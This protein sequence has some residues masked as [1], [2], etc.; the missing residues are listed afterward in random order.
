MATPRRLTPKKPGS[1]HGGGNYILIAMPNPNRA[2]AFRAAVASLEIETVLVRDGEK[3]NQ[4]LGRRG[5]PILTIVDLSLPKIDGFELLRELRKQA[6]SSEAAVIVVSGHSA[7]RMAAERL[8]ESLGISK[9]LPFDIDRTALREA[10]EK[11]LSDMTAR[12]PARPLPQTPE[13]EVPPY[14]GAE[15]A[16]E[17]AVIAAARRFRTAM[18][19]A[20]VKQGQQETVRGYF[21]VS[22]P[23]GSVSADHVLPFL[24][25]VAAGSDPLIVPNLSSYAALDE[26]APGGLQLVRGFAATPL[27]ARSA[28]ISGALC[29]LDTKPL[30]IDATEL[31]ALDALAR[32]LTRDLEAQFKTP[33]DA[34][35]AGGASSPVDID[36]LER[37]AATDALTG[38]ANRRGGEK[39]ISVEISRARRHRTPLSCALVDLD[40]FKEVNDTFGHQTGDYVLREIGALLR[41]MLRAYDIIVRWGGEEFLIV[42]PAVELEQARKLGERIRNAIESLTLA[43]IGGVTASVGVA[44][45]E[46]DF[47]FETMFAVADRRLYTAKSGGRNTVA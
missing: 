38:L 33:E 2:G 22:D 43:G 32:D 47:A 36:S 14:V 7:V 35:G 23:S 30:S 4:E 12:Q 24:R 10:V 15:N 20:Y 11:T 25:Q 1:P 5:A 13:T 34:T 17:I 8:A 29:L 27:V 40:H 42:L 6:P 31:D 28:E 3:A 16:I 39:D 41:R 45:L 21:A 46:G 37:L 26:V 44:Q 9:V 19:V 18:T